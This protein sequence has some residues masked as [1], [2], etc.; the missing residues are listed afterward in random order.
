MPASAESTHLRAT[1]TAAFQASLPP[2]APRPAPVP[3]PSPAETATPVP[4]R[5]P[6][7]EFVVRRRQAP[8]PEIQFVVNLGSAPVVE[9]EE[10]GRADPVD[11]PS[12][13]AR[14]ELLWGALATIPVTSRIVFREPERSMRKTESEWPRPWEARQDFLVSVNFVAAQWH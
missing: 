4:E 6:R 7:L 1:S 12:G 10:R 2:E 11:G 9:E 8:E 13:Y 5:P 3:T 14:E